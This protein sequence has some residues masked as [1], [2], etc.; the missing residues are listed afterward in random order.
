MCVRYLLIP[1][2]ALVGP[3]V[4]FHLASFSYIQVYQRTDLGSSSQRMKPS[5]TFTA[6]F[7]L[8]EAP[9]DVRDYIAPTVLVMLLSPLG[10]SLFTYRLCL[11][12]LG[13][14]WG[15]P[16][17]VR[18]RW[19]TFMKASILDDVQ[20]DLGMTPSV[21]ASLT[22]ILLQYHN[23]SIGL[24]IDVHSD[25]HSRP[26]ARFLRTLLYVE[27]ALNGSSEEKEQTASWLRWTHRHIHGSISDA[28]R[29]ELA[30]PEEAYVMQTLIWAAISF[31]DRFGKR[32]SARAR[33]AIVLEYACVG[34]RLGVPRS[35]LATTYDD[36]LVSFNRN[37][38]LLDGSSEFSTAGI[39][40]LE[41]SVLSAQ[42]CGIT[43]LFIRAALMVGHSLLPERVKPKYRLDILKSRTAQIVQRALCT[44][45]WLVYYS[46]PMVIPP[47][48]TIC[49]LLVLEP[50][51]RPIFRSSLQMIHCMD[52]LQDK[53][54]IPKSEGQEV[55][56][57]PVYISWVGSSQKRPYLLQTILVQTLEAQLRSDSWLNTIR[58]WFVYPF[59]I[60][61]TLAQFAIHGVGYTV[62]MWRSQLK[63]SSL[64]HSGREPKM[65]QHSESPLNSERGLTVVG[66]GVIMDG[67]RRYARQLGQHTVVGHAKG[68]ATAFKVLEWWIKHLPNTVGYKSPL[69]PKHLT[70]WAFSSENFDRSEE[71]RDGLFAI[72]ATE[73]KSIAF[74]KLVHLFQVRVRFIGGDRYRFPV[75]LVAAMDIVEEMTSTYNGLFLQIA[76]GYGGRQEV[77]SAVQSLMGQGKEITE[78]NI[79]IETYCAQRDVPPVNLIVRTSE[80]RTSGFFLWDTQSAELH[81]IDKLWP[82]FT[83]LD[84]LQSLESFSARQIRGGR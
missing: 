69:K 71:E 34:M 68:A 62:Q 84:W 6:R 81:F 7:Q 16:A 70:Y 75:E 57:L 54:V 26:L 58:V 43:A 44:V 23:P 25:V 49:L 40:K 28:K 27:M 66:V 77:V 64:F 32:L 55:S 20:I 37:L 59:N 4:R 61:K 15:G 73:F 35:L 41:V 19:P 76:M 42:T 82:Q 78:Q 13:I 30:I 14:Y 29:K 50:Q 24:A 33:D 80:R 79:V 60:A 51:L 11:T 3:N 10:L 47:R 53:P 46:F 72:M 83:E 22:A 74:T 17:L 31:E 38:E 9:C 45:V 63:E 67:N 18:L 52:I 39:R 65:P 36:F 1:E 21:F 56:E 5:T 2:I 12:A 8:V 48:G